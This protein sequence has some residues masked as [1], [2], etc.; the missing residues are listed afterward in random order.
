MHAF[1]C[2]FV[3]G[4][5][6][7]AL[8][9]AHRVHGMQGAASGRGKGLPRR[10]YWCA[11]TAWHGVGAKEYSLPALSATPSADRIALPLASFQS[12]SHFPAGQAAHS[13]AVLSAYSP[14]TH[15]LHVVSV[16]GV[17]SPPASNTSSGLQA[18]HGMHG[19]ARRGAD[20][21]VTLRK[22]VCAHG[23][24]R[25]GPGWVQKSTHCPR[26]LRRHRRI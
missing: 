22:L 9:G 6:P 19:A 25:R 4:R 8:P 16:V 18:L 5:A 12:A 15:F 21:R 26:F 20:A 13:L 11:H 3:W 2:M 24:A 10:G 23:V 17:H 1:T 14:A 7:G